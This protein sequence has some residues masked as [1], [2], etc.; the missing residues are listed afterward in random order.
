MT[1][2]TIH[3]LLA[4]LP[5]DEQTPEAMA[6]ILS[7]RQAFNMTKQRCLNPKCR[8][9]SFYGGRGITICD[10]WLVSFKHYLSDMGLKPAGM[11]LERKDNDGPYS[12]ENCLW[13]SRAAQT[14]NRRMTKTLTVGGV[15]RTLPE[16]SAITGIAYHTLKAR[17]NVLKYNPED[18][19][20]KPVVCGGLLPGRV[21]KP[22]VRRDM[23][24]LVPKGFNSKATAL[25]L[26]Q[27]SEIRTKLAQG[28]PMTKLAVEYGVHS[29][30]IKAVK[31]GTGAYSAFN[32]LGKD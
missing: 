30:T 1:V 21:Y 27:V 18:V 23:R 20:G 5:A 8:D 31:F 17:I 14:S 3:E 32:N 11:T 12:P 16:W 19:I 13:A 2:L 22:I 10:R 6:T 15:T 24:G 25:N 28:Q 29:A 7:M 9:Y 4:G 26:E